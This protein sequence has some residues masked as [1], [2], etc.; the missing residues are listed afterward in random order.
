MKNVT[1]ALAV[2]FIGFY[3]TAMASP[4]WSSASVTISGIW[5]QDTT[6]AGTG[7]ALSYIQFSAQPHSTGC[8]LNGTL[9]RIGGN[10]D[11][12]KNVFTIATSAKLAGRSV[13]VLWNQSATN[14]CD[15]G[16]T[17]GYPV[18]IGLQML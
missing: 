8:S 5:A 6:D 9:W 17:T 11:N 18:V 15:G 7:P 14:Q 1:L 4:Q 2:A 3:G 12:V 16:G 13:K 10:A